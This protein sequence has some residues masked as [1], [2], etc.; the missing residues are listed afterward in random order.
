MKTEPKSTIWIVEDEP[1]ICCL[2]SDILLEFGGFMV[3][4]VDSADQVDA[5]EGDLIFLDIHGTKASRL[6]SNNA[7]V[8]TMSGDF[9][10]KPDMAKPFHY[11]E[12]ESFISSFIRAKT[13]AKAS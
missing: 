11:E 2:F 5:R 7:R 12:I 10:V 3:V 8:V 13:A 1:E 6:R 4:C 9:S